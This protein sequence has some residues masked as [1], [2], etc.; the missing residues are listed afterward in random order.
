MNLEIFLKDECDS[1]SLLEKLEEYGLMLD[2]IIVK[3]IE[4]EGEKDIVREVSKFEILDIK[5][6][7][8]E[9]DSNISINESEKCEIMFEKLKE[10]LLSKQLPQYVLESFLKNMISEVKL[11]NKNNHKK[12]REGDIVSCN[13]GFGLH[14]ENQN[15]L[16]VIVLRH[17][18]KDKYWVVP[19]ELKEN[20]QDNGLFC[21]EVRRNIDASY[22]DCTYKKDKAIIFLNRLQEVHIFRFS[23]KIGTVTKYFLN[24]I[25]KRIFLSNQEKIPLNIVLEELI[26][27][28]IKCIKKEENECQQLER[29]FEFIKISNEAQLLR[30]AFLNALASKSA[31]LKDLI[32]QLQ[33]NNSTLSKNAV[34]TKLRA[35]FVTWISSIYPDIFEEYDR[36]SLSTVLKFF[37]KCYNELN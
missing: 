12:I 14:S 1:S 13:F 15:Y 30:E 31:T 33:I 8:T 35:E 6:T 3:D 11:I 20:F 32:P 28:A 7:N 16:N 22:Y 2:H 24:S 17:T 5:T 10:T 23:M 36:I 21:M 4:A 29:F 9:G 34:Q 25:Y 19:I 27:P 26:S 37:L 18:E